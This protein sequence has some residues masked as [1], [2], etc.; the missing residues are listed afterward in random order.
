MGFR[1][2]CH[3]NLAMLAKQ[4]WRLL[5][6][7]TSL[8]ARVFKGRYYP[9]TSFIQAKVGHNSSYTWKSQLKARHILSDGCVWRIRDDRSVNIWSDKW[10][11]HP[12]HK[13]LVTPAK[14]D[15]PQVLISDL[16]CQ[17]QRNWNEQLLNKLFL[18]ID[19]PFILSTPI[20]RKTSSRYIDL[21]LFEE[22]PL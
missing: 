7:N 14:D 5:H 13:N 20:P 4:G 9:R 18:S 3:F 11:F 6:N 21:A 10:F 19:I 15:C 8:V 22:L 16:I 1:G 12:E 17:D 2:M